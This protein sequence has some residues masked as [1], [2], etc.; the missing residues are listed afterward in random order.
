MYELLTSKFLVQ[1]LE[2]SVNCCHLLTVKYTLFGVKVKNCSSNIMAIKDFTDQSFSK[3][4]KKDKLFKVYKTLQ[5]SWRH[6]K[7]KEEMSMICTM[8]SFVSLIVIHL[9]IHMKKLLDSDWLRVVQF[10][11]TTSAKSVTPVQITHRN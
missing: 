2:Q 9:K 10:K 1:T 7:L 6:I 5:L 11:C 8:W 3:I 4:I